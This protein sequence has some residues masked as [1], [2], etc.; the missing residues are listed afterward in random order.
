[1]SLF[2]CVLLSIKQF[3]IEHCMIGIDEWMRVPSVEDVFALGDCAGFL[4]KT[5][6]QVLP[7][8]AQIYDKIHHEINQFCSAQSLRQVYIDM[9]D[10]IDEKMKDALQVDCTRYA[11][12]IEILSVRV[13]KP[14]IPASIKHNFEQMEKESTKVLIAMERQMVAEK[15]AETQKKISLA[16][17]EMNA[18]VSKILMEQ[19]LMEKDSSKRQQE[20]ENHM[21]MAREKSLTDA[22]FYKVMKE[23]EANKL[24]HPSILSSGLLNL[25]QT[26]QRSFSETRCQTWSMIRGCLGILQAQI[27]SRLHIYNYFLIHFFGGM[28]NCALQLMHGE[29][30]VL[31]PLVPIREVHFLRFCK[32]HAEGVWAVVDVSVDMNRDTSNPQTFVSSRRLPSG[33]VVQDMPNGYSKCVI[34]G[35]TTGAIIEADLY[36]IDSIET[37]LQTAYSLFTAGIG[38]EG[39]FADGSSADKVN[40][41]G[42]VLRS[43]ATKESCEGIVRCFR[44]LLRDDYDVRHAN[45]PHHDA[46]VIMLKIRN[47]VL[48]KMMINTGSSIELLFQSTIDQMRLADKVQPSD[49]N[50]CGFNGF[51][52]ER[53]GKIILSIT[54]LAGKIPTINDFFSKSS[55]RCRWLFDLLCQGT[56]KKKSK[57]DP[58]IEW[59]TKYEAAFQELKRYLGKP[60]VMSTPTE[61]EELTIYLVVT[62]ESLS[63]VLICLDEKTEKPIYFISKPLTL[64]ESWYTKIKKL[65]LALMYTSQKL[66]QYFQAYSVQVM[67]NYPLREILF[68]REKSKRVQQ[69][70]VILGKHEIRF[71]PRYSE[72]GH[73]AVNFLVDFPVKDPDWEEDSAD[74]NKE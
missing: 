38:G 43:D 58:E 61:R 22:D 27:F 4:D 30:Q 66:K 68:K 10:Q 15:E 69:W 37:R 3:S 2:W 49:I 32:Q 62:D 51:R 7:A 56:T 73:A 19:K 40:L 26:I 18:Q 12:G 54:K 39:A 74:I 65:L 70:S 13:T 1:M 9:F 29:L 6:K 33:Y 55:D 50:I 71:E 63:Y 14:T 23:A 20:I 53:V 28:K 72:K 34:A 24:S 60:P 41:W 59:I 67:T 47:V 52:E 45:F 21:Y 36:P 11:P 17:A 46:L 31:S 64:A 48:H 42:A 8:L 16:E 5:G 44:V 25:L 35:G 57:K